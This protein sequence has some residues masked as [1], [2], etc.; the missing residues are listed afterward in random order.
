[1][2]GAGTAGQGSGGFRRRGDGSRFTGVAIQFITLVHQHHRNVFYNGVLPA[3]SHGRPTRSAGG[4]QAI[5]FANADGSARFPVA[6]GLTVFLLR[7]RCS[8]SLYHRMQPLSDLNKMIG[9]ERA[10]PG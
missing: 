6:Y 9:R 7:V 2:R 8:V 5:F 3:D 4:K 1:M 10:L